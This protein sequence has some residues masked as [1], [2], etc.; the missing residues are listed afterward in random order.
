M[1][2]EQLEAFARTDP[3]NAELGLSLAEAYLEAGRTQEVLDLLARPA[4]CELPRARGLLARAHLMRANFAAAHALLVELCEQEPAHAVLWHDQAYAAMCLGD[5]VG[6]QAAIERALALAEQAE[7]HLLAARIAHGAEAMDLASTYIARA[8]ELAPGR[9]ETLGLHAL[10]DLDCGREDAAAEH[11]RAALAQQPLQHESLIVLSAL[12]LRAQDAA[13]TLHWAQHGLSAY[14]DSA[15]LRALQAQAL[16]LQGELEVAQAAAQRAVSLQPE[17]LG[18]WHV[19]AWTQLLQGQIDQ[20]R[21]SFEQAFDRD[22]SFAET[23][24]GLA[25]VH[26]LQGRAQEAD[27]WLKRARRLDASSPTTIYA[28]V[29]RDT[30]AGA[31]DAHAGL[32]GLLARLPGYAG[33]DSRELLDATLRGLRGHA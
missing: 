32:Q 28:G 7:F 13:A 23:L 20:A 18:G 26:A 17:H 9:P 2:I 12:A 22:H 21:S 33:P 5:L 8:L 29:L 4:L 11:A 16:L 3:D 1:Q 24:G 31:K 10:V 25:L 14:P 30:L 6:A 27:R 19:L 15:R